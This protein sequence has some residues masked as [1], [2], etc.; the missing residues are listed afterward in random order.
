M[1]ARFFSRAF[2]FKLLN[3]LDD[4]IVKPDNCID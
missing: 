3:Y 1:G 4:F 2:F